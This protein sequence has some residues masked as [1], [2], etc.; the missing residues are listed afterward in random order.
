VPVRVLLIDD[1]GAERDITTM[2]KGFSFEH[3]AGDVPEMVLHL[4]GPLDLK[5]EALVKFEARHDARDED[6]PDA[7]A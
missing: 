1:D 4:L 3:F 2:V 6:Q 5:G 7:V